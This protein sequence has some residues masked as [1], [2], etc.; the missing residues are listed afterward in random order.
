MALHL[1]FNE[2]SKSSDTRLREDD[3]M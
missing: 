3:V 2:S 1:Y